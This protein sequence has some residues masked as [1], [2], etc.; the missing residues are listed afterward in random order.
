MKKA[1]RAKRAAPT[2]DLLRQQL[3]RIAKLNGGALEARMVVDAARPKRSPLHSQFEWDD[4]VAA[5]AHRLHQARS[6]I[7][8]VH[9]E[10]V[11]NA[12]KAPVTV[13]LFH[14]LRK[15]K[16]GYRTVGDIAKSRPAKQA[17]LDQLLIDLRGMQARYEVLRTLFADDR[18]VAQLFGAID[19]VVTRSAKQ[20]C[21]KPQARTAA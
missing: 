21:K 4:S 19:K 6:L 13:R 11:P 14:Q 10:V 17:L 3:E 5:E 15:D 7:A 8:R 18:L 20:A 16:H 2:N 12:S 9:I 1:L